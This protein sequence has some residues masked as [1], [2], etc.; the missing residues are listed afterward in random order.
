MC[1]K[2]YLVRRD[3]SICPGFHVSGD[4]IRDSAVH[5]NATLANL[6]EVLYKD[7]DFKTVSAVVGAVFCAMLA[8]ETGSI[9]N[10]IEKGHP[11]IVPS[12]AIQAT[13]RQLRNYPVGLEVKATVGNVTK[14]ANLRAGQQRLQE[15]TGI[16]WQ[17]HHREVTELVGI[18]WDF[19]SVKDSFRFPTITGIF[20]AS[21]LETEDWGVISGTSGRNTKVCGM[22]VSGKKKMGGGWVLAVDS[23][24]YVAKFERILTIDD[25]SFQNDKVLPHSSE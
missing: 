3:F 1:S 16:T 21:D 22:R 23:K 7:I 5:T 25:G 2:M 9:V 17:A 12:N 4:N 18:V 6:P 24:D 15:L 10:P 19:L 20:Y 14:G 13:E 11:D 8:T